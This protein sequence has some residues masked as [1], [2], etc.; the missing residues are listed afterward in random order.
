M[1][2]IAYAVKNGRPN[3]ASGELAYHVL[4]AMHGFHDAADEGKHY[5]MQSSCERPDSMP[6]GLVRGMLD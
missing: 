5:L 6:F 2:D 4:E 3:R 1:L